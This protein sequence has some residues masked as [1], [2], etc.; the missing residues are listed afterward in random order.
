MIDSVSVQTSFRARAR[1]VSVATTGSVQ[2]SATTTGYHRASGSFIADGFQ[3]GMEIT[4]V[5]GF[6]TSG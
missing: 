5:T 6:S 4:Y 3:A 1:T 2:L